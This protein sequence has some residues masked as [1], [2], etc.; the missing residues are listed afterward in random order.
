LDIREGLTFDDVLL[1]PKFSD[2]KIWEQEEHRQMSIL[3]VYPNE[4]PTL[5][6]KTVISLSCS[7][8]IF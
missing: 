6:K 4:P 1:V 5:E 8:D 2:V 7:H 3:L